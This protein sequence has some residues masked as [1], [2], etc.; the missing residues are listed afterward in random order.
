MRFA[1]L[2]GG[3]GGDVDRLMT[4]IA[5]WLAAGGRTPVGVVRDAAP[6]AGTHPCE[7]RLRVLPDG[8][9]I[10]IDQPLGA[11]STG[12]R[13]DPDALERAVVEVERRLARPADI[14]LLNKFGRQEAEGRGFRTAIGLA[15]DHGLPVLLGVGRFSADPFDSF[16]GGLAETLPCEAVAVRDWCRRTL[17]VPAL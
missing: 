16:A 14:F 2:R 15:L 11:G 8:P 6:R 7:M 13:L 3:Q 12:C 9:R 4:G 5:D 1:V 17:G 10:A